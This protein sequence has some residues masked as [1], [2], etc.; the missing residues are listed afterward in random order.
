MP[1]APPSDGAAPPSD[2]T[3]VPE[4]RPRPRR[5][6]RVPSYALDLLIV[7]HG[8]AGDRD[9]WAKTGQDDD[10]R[11]LTPDGMR[12]M[13]R[14]ARGLQQLVKSVDAIGTSPLV[15]ARE[16]AAILATVYDVVPE[17]SQV[18]GD[19]DRHGI[20]R[21]VRGTAARVA[22]KRRGKEKRVTIAIVGHE[23]DLS[24][25][26][27]WLLTGRGPDSEGESWMELKKGGAIFLS[28]GGRP[29]P[30]TARLR[31]LLTRTQLERVKR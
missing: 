18:I 27:A 13:R 19:G 17:E 22:K 7:R 23:P 24:A 25:S 16:T 28:F 20:L 8:P 2:V 31:W 29:K 21:W 1:P 5:A 9:E 15:R 26:A 3:V 6:A 30:R 12:Q 4:T 11:P 14:A 10:E